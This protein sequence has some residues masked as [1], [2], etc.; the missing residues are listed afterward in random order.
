M[1]KRYG[2]IGESLGHSFSPEVHAAFGNPDYRLYEVGRGALAGFLQGGDFG[3]FNV[4]MP[5]KEAVIPYCDELS[6]TARRVGAVNLLVKR[7]GRLVGGN[8]DYYGLKRTLERAG[9]DPRGKKV[10]VL[11]SGGTSKTARAVLAEMGAGEAVVI[12]R[13]GE[14][15]YQNLTKHRDTR[16]IINTTPVGMYPQSGEAPVS[17][18]GFPQLEG[19]CDVIFNPLRTRLLQEAEALGLKTAG[20][21]AMLVYQAAEAHESFF[22]GRVDER[23]CERVLAGLFA[24]R[25]SIVLVGMPGCGKSHI[26]SLLQKESGMTVADV[27]AII[28]KKAGRATA[29][30]LAREGEKAFRELEHEAIHRVT[31]SGGL[32]VATG[33]GA[34]KTPENEPLLRQNGRVYYIKRAASRLKKT[35][36]PLSAGRGAVWGLFH[37]RNR[38]Y[39]RVCDVEID[40]NGSIADCVK[41]ILED[42]HEYTGGERT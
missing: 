16:L 38:L 30:I 17:L 21:L 22:E 1:E 40:N 10:L 35:G 8:T 5:Y 42:F 7:G 25:C 18:A 20:G 6:E 34:V 27:D 24:R 4:T 37:E 9:I 2:L 36:R 31:E 26:A 41:A 23:E 14:N 3:G 15:N 13:S 39:R 12:S 33:G 29:E 28:E 32:I 19:V 11:G